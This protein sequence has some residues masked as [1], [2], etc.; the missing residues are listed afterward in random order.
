M[1]AH[2]DSAHLIL[3][4]VALGDVI[5]LPDGREK[6]IRAREVL[7]LPIQTMAGFLIAGELDVLLSTPT[8][9]GSPV[10][11]YVPL[12]DLPADTR[13]ARAVQEGVISYWAPHLPA[14]SGA[15]GEL[16]Y[17]IVEVSGWIDPIVMVWRGHEVTVFVRA[18]W[19]WPSDLQVLYMR[20]DPSNNTT[21]TRHSGVVDD[22][23]RV[24]EPVIV[25]QR[26]PEQVPAPVGR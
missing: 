16:K 24:T 22:P 11:V 7:S 6:T 2:H 25:P 17:K 20:R 19:A 15:M 5:V 21:V 12:T 9:A 14:I 26:Q 23:S 4:D 13:T 10:L 1:A 8:S 3:A 18:T